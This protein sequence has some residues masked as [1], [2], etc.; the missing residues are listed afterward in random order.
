MTA[1]KTALILA[2]AFSGCVAPALLL[3]YGS[4]LFLGAVPSSGA[5]WLAFAVTAGAGVGLLLGW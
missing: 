2:L 1:K 5:I 4:W 3:G